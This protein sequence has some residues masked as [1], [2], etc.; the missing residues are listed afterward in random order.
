MILSGND[1]WLEQMHSIESNVQCCFMLR[2]AGIEWRSR[3][4]CLCWFC[5]CMSFQSKL[6]LRHR[7]QS[8]F[9][10]YNAK[11]KK[12]RFLQARALPFWIMTLRFNATGTHTTCRCWTE[13]KSGTSRQSWL[14]SKVWWWRM[15]LQ[16]LQRWRDVR[17][18]RHR[19]SLM[20]EENLKIFSLAVPE[21]Y[22]SFLNRFDRCSSWNCS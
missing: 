9:A 8:Q 13:K 15:L 2:S 7:W 3:F 18:L 22:E 20:N 21:L 17:Q 12:I 10:S 11:K 19:C 6:R 5:K 4:R 14:P 16:Q 1:C